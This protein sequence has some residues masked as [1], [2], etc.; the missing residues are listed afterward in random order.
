[1][2][3]A[4]YVNLEHLGSFG[5]QVRRNH[6]YA[7]DANRTMDLRLALERVVGDNAVQRI[8]EL[9]TGNWLAV[10]KVARA[11]HWH[12]QVQHDLHDNLMRGLF[13]MQGMWTGGAASQ[14]QDAMQRLVRDGIASHAG[15]LWEARDPRLPPP[16]VVSRPAPHRGDDIH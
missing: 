4:F 1:M 5:N 10:E 13:A 6:L 9:I 15:F 8:S 11:L 14:M 7:L 3:S 2:A 12:G 16:P